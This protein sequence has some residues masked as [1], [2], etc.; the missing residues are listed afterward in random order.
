MWG[1]LAQLLVHCESKWSWTANMF[2]IF[3]DRDQI[4]FNCACAMEKQT[5]L[6]AP[7]THAKKKK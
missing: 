6:V 7:R 1:F 4:P 5:T 3:M 2:T